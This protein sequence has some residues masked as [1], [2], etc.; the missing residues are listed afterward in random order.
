MTQASAAK[1]EAAPSVQMQE[2]TYFVLIN[3]EF[4]QKAAREYLRNKY[5]NSDARVVQELRLDRLTDKQTVIALYRGNQRTPAV[6][7]ITNPQGVRVPSATPVAEL[8]AE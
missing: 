8:A 5:P 1:A 3:D 2:T 4:E 7:L 6:Q